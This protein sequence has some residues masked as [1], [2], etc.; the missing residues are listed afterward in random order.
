MNLKGVCEVREEKRRAT[1]S[2]GKELIGMKGLVQHLDRWDELYIVSKETHK[3]TCK[4]A[5]QPGRHVSYQEKPK[6]SK[7]S[8]ASGHR[9]GHIASFLSILWISLCRRTPNSN[10]YK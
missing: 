5:L 8:I 7:N 4:G 6:V 2:H 10:L 3:S 9:V 1:I